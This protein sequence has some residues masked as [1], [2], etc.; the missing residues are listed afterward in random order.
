MPMRLKMGITSDLENKS[1]NGY[2]KQKGKNLYGRGNLDKKFNKKLTENSIS[3]QNSNQLDIAHKKHLPAKS[4]SYN[5][6][7]TKLIN[8]KFVN[9]EARILKNPRKSTLKAIQNIYN[10]ADQRFRVKPAINHAASI[11]KTRGKDRSTIS[12]IKYASKKNSKKQKSQVKAELNG[13]VKAAK[14]IKEIK[15][16]V[17]SNKNG[18]SENADKK[19][20]LPK[21]P[22]IIHQKYDFSTDDLKEVVNQVKMQLNDEKELADSIKKEFKKEQAAAAIQQAVRSVGKKTLFKKIIKFVKEEYGDLMATQIEK[23]F[24]LGRKKTE[25]RGEIKRD[26]GMLRMQEEEFLHPVLEGRIVGYDEE[27]CDDA[28]ISS[29]ESDDEYSDSSENESQDNNMSK[30]ELDAY[31]RK[32][33][34]LEELGGRVADREVKHKPYKI[35]S[36][37]L[38]K[39]EKQIA[40][41][42]IEKPFTPQKSNAQF[43]FN[44]TGMDTEISLNEIMGQRT[45][46]ANSGFKTIDKKSEKKSAMFETLDLMDITHCVSAEKKE[47]MESAKQSLAKLQNGDMNGNGMLDY[48][49]N[50]DQMAQCNLLDIVDIKTGNIYSS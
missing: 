42:I 7:P 22:V 38:P 8:K 36:I 28:S 45:S 6:N 37:K 47:T 23:V 41:E 33:M 24:G 5:Q 29:D 13:K 9:M 10:T 12:P 14:V 1:K 16:S 39:P 44:P 32:R 35:E 19:N 20:C 18:K 30:K 48:S 31:D 49:H 43:N 34:I 25:R 26:E 15:T 27:D 4:N 40:P 50:L 21:F 11:T 3:Y 46:V 2:S 17:T